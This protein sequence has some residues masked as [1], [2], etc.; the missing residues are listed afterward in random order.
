M[1]INVGMFYGVYIGKSA[2][3]WR[4]AVVTSALPVCPKLRRPKTVRGIDNN[5]IK[6]HVQL[7][8]VRLAVPSSC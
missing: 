6:Q 5:P 8:R 3:R 1:A 4:A 2:G 7:L